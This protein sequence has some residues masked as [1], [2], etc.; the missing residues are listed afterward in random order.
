MADANHTQVH[1]LGNSC[2]LPRSR[3]NAATLVIGMLRPCQAAQPVPAGTDSYWVCC[4]VYIA[5]RLCSRVR[6]ASHRTSHLQ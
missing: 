4:F 2:I 1:M 6:S 3:N 5:C